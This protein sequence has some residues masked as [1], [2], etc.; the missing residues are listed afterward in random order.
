MPTSYYFI[1]V[2]TALIGWVTNVIAVKMLF[3]PREPLS[4]GFFTIQGAVPRRRAALGKAIAKIAHEELFSV[5]ELSGK[6]RNMDVGPEFGAMV[7]K[8]MDSFIGGIK[9]AIP[10]ASMFLQGSMLDDLKGRAR[11][12]FS[13]LLP[14]IK[15]HVGVAVERDLDLHGH[16]EEK[17][18]NFSVRKMEAIVM[19]VAT[20]E[21]KTIEWLGGLLG[22]LIGLAQVAVMCAI[23]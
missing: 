5:E 14:E 15:E 3:H 16:I 8:R 9:E 19:R 22:L 2:V 6:L 18:A 13:Q 10:M 7:D 11:K 20:K 17:V 21:L 12:E 1:P 23:A 4:L